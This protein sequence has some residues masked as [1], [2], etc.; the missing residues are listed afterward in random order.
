VQN[1]N[2]RLSKKSTSGIRGVVYH[3]K[4]KRWQ[5]FINYHGNKLYL[6]SFTDKDQATEARKKAQIQYWAS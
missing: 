5:A 6:G 4:K 2:T 1:Q 3:T